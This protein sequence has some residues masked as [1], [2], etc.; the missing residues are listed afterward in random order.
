MTEL[1]GPVLSVVKARD[2][3][4]AIKIVNDTGYGLT[5]GI[6]SLDER[7]VAYWRE[8]LKAG[9]LYINR[10]T[11]GAIVLRQPFGG[12]GKSAI[13]AGRKVGIHNYITQFVDFEEVGEPKIERSIRHTFLDKI[14][15]W[16]K[17]AEHGIHVGFKADFEKLS[18]AVAS[19]VQNYEDEFSQEKDYVKVRGE[20]N[21]FR[22]LPLSKIALRVSAKDSLFDV[23]ARIAGAKI[24]GSALHVS[25]EAGLENS[26]VSFIYENKEHLLGTNDTLV[27]ENEEVF[28]QC[29]DS[30]QKILYA[31]A[32]AISAYVYDQAAKSAT[33]IVRAHPLMEGRIEL[34]HFFQEQSI[35]HSYHRYGNIGARAIDKQ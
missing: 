19:Y 3:K 33:F 23:I 6:E 30:V 13:G 28:A 16:S 5:S 35:S 32:S 9:N 21:I 27:R 29:F 31:H 8:N 7:E 10:G 20:D 25:I 22:Y 17:G 34:L 4:H 15:T 18:L 14:A 1:F 26:V 2:L 11:T 24:A 12:M